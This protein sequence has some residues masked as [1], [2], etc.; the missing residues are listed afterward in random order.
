MKSNFHSRWEQ[1]GIN[2]FENFQGIKIEWERFLSGAD[3]IDHTIVSD[4]VFDAWTRCHAMGVDPYC[5]PEQTILKGKGL[6]KLIDDNEFFINASRPF[7]QNLSTFLKG[8]GFLVGLF[9]KSGHFLEILGDDDAIEHAKRGP[10]IVGALWTEKIAGNNSVGT[11]LELKRPIQIFA[12]EHYKK[13]LHHETDSSAPIFDAES[14]FIGGIC[15]SGRYYRA[16]PHTLGLVVAAAQAIEN[17]L[18]TKKALKEV[19]IAYSY[20]QTA[21]SSIPEAIVAIGVDGCIKLANRNAQK[22]LFPDMQHIEGK[23]IAEILGKDNSGFIKILENDELIN[24]VEVTIFTKN[25]SNDYIMMRNPIIGDDQELIG[26]III[27]T[28]IK[29][30]KKRVAQMLGNRANFSFTHILGQNAAF[31]QIK[32]RALIVSKSNANILLLGESGTGKDIFAQ[33][34]HNEGE[35]KDGPYIPIN[36][37]AIPRDLITS[38]LFGYADGA[39][40]G[41]RRGGNQGKFELADGGT[42]FLD[43]VAE[44]PLELQA[45][46][47]RVIEDKTVTRLGSKVSRPINVRVIAA[48]NKDL[49]KETDTG[50]FRKDLFYRL[51]VFNIHM[52]PLRERQDDIPLL[53]EYFVKQYGKTLGKEHMRIEK[54]VID[55]FQHYAWPGNIRELQNVVERMVHFAQSNVVTIN[56]L[57]EEINKRSSFSNFHTQQHLLTPKQFEQQQIMRLMEAKVSKTDI[58]RKMGMSRPTLYRKLREYTP[59]RRFES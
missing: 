35:Q 32:E 10:V 38:E 9:D 12:S 45:V 36:C 25:N 5:V 13:Y 27:L 59:A 31:V 15:L 7:M 51:N 48:T 16:N 49:Q 17:T 21:F 23:N 34:I 1:N 33:A 56:L 41:S 58:A 8:S 30:A 39:Y 11:V 55:V 14:T 18:K 54:S 6:A 53:V 46:L 50:N 22:M 57:P 37:A 28:E 4:E 52:I 47:L 40:T 29:R 44:I 43:E 24:D 3:D 20:Q 2:Y 26:Q 42:L 19:R